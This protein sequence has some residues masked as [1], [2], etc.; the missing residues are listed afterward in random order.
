M[1]ADSV[2]NVIISN[3]HI[4]QEIIEWLVKKLIK[5]NATQIWKDALEAYN[6]I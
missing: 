4:N 2:S 1:E 6:L 3:T 5:M